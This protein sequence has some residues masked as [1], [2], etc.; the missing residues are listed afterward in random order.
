[1]VSL[2][3]RV[4]VGFLVLP[5]HGGVGVD[6]CGGGEGRPSAWARASRPMLSGVRLGAGEVAVD[7]SPAAAAGPPPRLSPWTAGPVACLPQG[8]VTSTAEGGVSHPTVRKR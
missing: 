2:E 6:V 8:W 4:P 5:L 3:P 7:P 1:M